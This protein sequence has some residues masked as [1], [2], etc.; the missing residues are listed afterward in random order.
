M[1]RDLVKA[2]TLSSSSS[3]SLQRQRGQP[4]YSSIK[5]Q[6]DHL[7]VRK[8]SEF[9]RIYDKCTREQYLILIKLFTVISTTIVQKRKNCRV[10]IGLQPKTQINVNFKVGYGNH[11]LPVLHSYRQL[12]DHLKPTSQEREHFLPQ[13]DYVHMALES[14]LFTPLQL[15]QQFPDFTLSTRN[16]M[17]TSRCAM[18][19]VLDLGN[20]ITL[21]L[22]Y[23]VYGEYHFVL[24]CENVANAYIF[25]LT[26]GWLSRV[27]GTRGMLGSELASSELIAILSKRH[28]GDIDVTNLYMSIKQNLC[29]VVT[30]PIWLRK[31]LYAH[32]DEM[33][34]EC[35][36]KCD[37]GRTNTVQRYECKFHEAQYMCAQ[38]W[39]GINH[40][41][42]FSHECVI[43]LPSGSFG[44]YSW[45]VPT[46]LSSLPPT[47][48]QI[49]MDITWQTEVFYKANN[50]VVHQIIVTG[51]CFSTKEHM[52]NELISQL[53]GFW[54]TLSTVCGVNVTAQTWRPIHSR[55]MLQWHSSTRQV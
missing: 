46:F 8:E 35:F 40:L 4:S 26:N 16:I 7:F 17:I 6:Y 41:L 5:F 13:V 51:A 29:H 36:N 10:Y 20:D 43:L 22:W 45:F 30:E 33:E 19:S 2:S 3:M 38:K 27:L 37:S 14:C 47:L 55:S 50:R 18:K 11:P 9:R 23:N 24:E 54:R 32:I 28:T 12:A 25:G 52:K 21:A 42:T 53:S 1:I 39:N 49:L 31:H 44:G 15:A 48:L 34:N